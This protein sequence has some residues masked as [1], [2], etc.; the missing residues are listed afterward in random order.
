M[1]DGL[2]DNWGRVHDAMRV[3]VTDR[4]NLRCAYCMPSEGME[5]VPRR[6]VL[7]YE[8][9][10]FAAKVAVDLGVTRFRITGGEPLLRRDLSQFV[11]MLKDV[12]AADVSMTTNGVLLEGHAD[13]LKAAGLDRLN[14]SMDSL[15]PHRFE[16]VTRWGLLTQVWRG[17]EA[18]EAAGLRPLKINALILKGFNDDE[19]DGWF[20]L[21]RDRDVCVRFMELMPMGDNALAALGGFFDLTAFRERAVTTLGLRPAAEVHHGNGPAEYWRGQGWRGSVGFI[22]P[23]SNPYCGACRRLR[24]TCTGELRA[25]LAFDESVQIKAALQR[26]DEGAVRAAFGW[27]VANKKFSHPW[28]DGQ[29]TP[30]GMSALGG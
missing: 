5:F 26:R 30:T 28:L 19:F 11:G 25:C 20:A 3:S 14:V 17:I 21:A 15:D 12:G 24:L 23:I 27:A 22:T 29:T 1:P 18:A 6:D 4:C 7:S 16:R 13:R 2:K 8:E 9:L 10:A